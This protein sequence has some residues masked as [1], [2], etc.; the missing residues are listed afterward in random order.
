[1][2]TRQMP[3]QGGANVSEDENDKKKNDGVSGRKDRL[4]LLLKK[5]VWEGAP[6]LVHYRK[7]ARF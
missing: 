3:S 7:K 2:A 1:V 4:T 5:G 6:P